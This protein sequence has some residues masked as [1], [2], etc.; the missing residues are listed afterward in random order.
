MSDSTDKPSNVLP[1]YKPVTGEPAF[2]VCPCQ[3]DG[4]PYTIVVMAHETH[5]IITGI[6]CPECEAHFSVVNGVVQYE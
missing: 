6:L 2:M 4:V 3:P 5:P 1:F